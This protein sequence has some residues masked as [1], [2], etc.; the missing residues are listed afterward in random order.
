MEWLETT[1]NKK[2][3]P[4]EDQWMEIIDLDI[5]SDFKAGH[6]GNRDLQ[7]DDPVTEDDDALIESPRHWAL[8]I[9]QKIRFSYIIHLITT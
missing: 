8:G 3:K 6:W 5:N 9:G 2:R 4:D 7:L 1:Y